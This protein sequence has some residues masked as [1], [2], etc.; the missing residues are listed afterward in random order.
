MNFFIRKTG[1]DL[2]GGRRENS[3]DGIRGGGP[4]G[5]RLR[6]TAFSTHPFRVSGASNGML[7]RNA[8]QT[9]LRGESILVDVNSSAVDYNLGDNLF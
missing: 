4:Y 1:P 7:A 6:V 2:P 3:G 9:L 8:K 5:E